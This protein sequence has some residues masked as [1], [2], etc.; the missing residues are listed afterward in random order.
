MCFSIASMVDL[1]K[2]F[3]RNIWLA[4]RKTPYL[5]QIC[6]GPVTNTSRVW[7]SVVL[8]FSNFRYHCNRCWS[9]SDISYIL[10]LAPTVEE[11]RTLYSLSQLQQ[12]VLYFVLKF[13][14]QWKQ[15]SVWQ[16]NELQCSIGRL[17]NPRYSGKIQEP[18]LNTSRVIANLVL[19]FLNL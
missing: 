18:V 3:N 14:L 1:A 10:K 19:K 11:S 2:I 16:K 6:E 13:T 9:E 12:T 5:V 17:P 8:K 4:D 15:G 7:V